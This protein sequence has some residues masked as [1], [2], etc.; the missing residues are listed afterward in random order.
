LNKQFNVGFELGLFKNRVSVT[1]D[2]YDRKSEDLLLNEPLSATSGF[3]TILR[4]AGS[5]Y[6]RGVEITVNVSPVQ[7]KDFRWNINFNIALN[8]NQITSISAGQNQ[9]L[10]GAFSRRVG[11]DFQTYF[12]RLWAGVDPANGDPLWYT[13]STKKSTTNNYNLAARTATYGSATPTFFGGF[14]NSI[15][16][17]GISLEAQFNYSGGNYLRDTWGGFYNGSGNGGAFNKVVRQYEQRWRT[18]GAAAQMPRYVYNG[19]RL[20][21][22][23][24]TFY[25]FRGDYLRLRDLTLGYDFPRTLLEKI[26]LTSLRVYGRGTNI[27]TKV[28]D[29]NVPFDPEQG[30]SNE[31]NL[32]VY[33][34]ATYTFGLNIGF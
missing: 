28:K 3:T 21:Q 27:W 23:F 1:M 31:T 5:M 32:N 8:K 19:N 29:G 34:P 2:Y 7:T 13:D 33:I 12:V 15:S 18:P 9:I 11:Y 22:S 6:N 4:N 30:V 10:S 14:T 25:L 26:K 17:K 20:A 24:S 16:F